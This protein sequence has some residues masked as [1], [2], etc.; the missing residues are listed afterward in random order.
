[1][2]QRVRNKVFFQTLSQMNRGK[3]VLVNNELL[4]SGGIAIATNGREK[5]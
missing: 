3:Y 4:G 2:N 5:Y 1:M